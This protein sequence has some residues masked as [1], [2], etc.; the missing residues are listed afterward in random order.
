MKISKLKDKKSWSLILYI[1]IATVLWQSCMTHAMVKSAKQLDSI[2]KL[3]DAY[4]SQYRLSTIGENELNEY[5]SS[6]QAMRD[7]LPDSTAAEYEMDSA[8]ISKTLFVKKDN[9]PDEVTM[10]VQLYT[11]EGKIL[12][13]F[14]PPYLD[15]KTDVYSIWHGLRDTNINDM[16]VNED[17]ICNRGEVF[18]PQQYSVREIRKTREKPKAICY[19]L[20][21]SGSMGSRS[22]YLEKAI[23]KMIIS[24]KEGD[25][26]SIVVFVGETE[27]VLPLTAIKDSAL[28]VFPLADNIKSDLQGGSSVTRALDAAVKEISLAP[29]GYDKYV[30]M[31]TDGMEVEDDYEEARIIESANEQDINVYSFTLR[32][33]NDVSRLKRITE[34]TEGRF[35]MMFQLKEIKYAFADMYLDKSSYYEITY[36]PV[37]C[38]GQH[39]VAADISIPVAGENFKLTSSGMYS[40]EILPPPTANVSVAFLEINFAS[41]SFEI[42]ENSLGTIKD[43]SDELKNK[44]PKLVQVIG[45]TDNVGGENENQVLSENRAKAV[46]EKL[47]ELGVPKNII[48]HKGAGELDPVAENT[49]EKGRA[50]NR[51]TELK[52]VWQ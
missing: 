19:L 42:E 38:R 25:L 29:D 6:L 15:K 39:G 32:G 50:L 51:R 48:N 12:Q 43:I 40:L 9:W 30:A 27:T 10:G 37:G 35:Y 17:L 8:I 36:K 24:S 5:I 46:M 47:I 20:D 13:G 18:V 7:S 45:H 34:R 41:G 2:Q 14:A 44:K 26:Y 28:A 31:M 21:L 33:M 22:E 52:I 23:R 3:A 16:S 11:A 49:T 4:S 1:G